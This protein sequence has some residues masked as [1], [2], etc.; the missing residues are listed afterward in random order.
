MSI[1][2]NLFL[3]LFSVFARESAHRRNASS[4]CWPVCVSG[5]RVP[6]WLYVTITYYHGSWRIFSADSKAAKA[7]CRRGIVE[8][9]DV[10]KLCSLALHV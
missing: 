10:A 8:E 3:D 1:L 2:M 5:G 4:S 6:Y 9:G 7:N